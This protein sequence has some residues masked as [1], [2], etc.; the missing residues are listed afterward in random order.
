MKEVI[1]KSRQT[2]FDVTIQEFG[3]LENLRDV[4]LANDLNFNDFLAQ[5]TVLEVDAE[6]KGNEDVKDFYKLN[7][8]IPQNN[9]FENDYLTCDIDTITC[10]SDLITCDQTIN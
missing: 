3:T 9:W 4:V 10:D 6:G 2:I 7:E 8:I 5:G 1:V